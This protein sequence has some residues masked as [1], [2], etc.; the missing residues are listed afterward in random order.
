MSRSH[1]HKHS[2][3]FCLFHRSVCITSE[4]ETQNSS[5]ARKAMMG[6]KGREKERKEGKERKG[7]AKG[8]CQENLITLQGA[9]PLTPPPEAKAQLLSSSSCS[10]HRMLNSLAC[11]LLLALLHA[12]LLQTELVLYSCRS[13]PFHT[14]PGSW[15]LFPEHLSSFAGRSLVSEVCLLPTPLSSAWAMQ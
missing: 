6:R 10:P 12:L 3:C 14:P 7:E 15:K 2:F 8:H 11:H 13:L 1:C 5:R 9:V 4:M